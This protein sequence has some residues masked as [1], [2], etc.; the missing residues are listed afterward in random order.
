MA[1]RKRTS[2][3][4]A[5]LG[6][7]AK[8]PW[9]VGVL[10]ALGTYV[11]FHALATRPVP[12]MTDSRQ[13]GSQLPWMLVSGFSVALQYVAPV[14][15]LVGALVSFLQRRK[16]TAL[17]A[18]VTASG[19]AQALDGMSWRDFELLVGEA[20]RPKCASPMIRRTATKGSNAGSQFWRCSKFPA[21]RGTR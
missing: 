5:I 20:F 12:T 4:E 19:S 6:L 13:L 3:A 11:I 14:I 2:G 15:C 21:C 18:N 16:R 9:W 10:L 8:L 7:V 17:A 1:R